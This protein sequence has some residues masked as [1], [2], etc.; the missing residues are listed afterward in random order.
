MPILGSTTDAVLQVYYAATYLV[1]YLPLYTRT[2]YL[3]TLWLTDQQSHSS[4]IANVLLFTGLHETARFDEFKSGIA[5]RGSSIRIPRQCAAEG[6][7]Y[8]EDRR[9]AANCDP[10]S[11]TEQ[12]VRTVCLNDTSDVPEPERRISQWQP[13]PQNL[14]HWFLK[15][16]PLLHY[17]AL[18]IMNVAV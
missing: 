3:T 2:I 6:C 1:I 5:A 9:P 15:A 18:R 7:G 16:F 8:R 10:Y 17:C 14:R 4:L 13:V 12:I 11:V